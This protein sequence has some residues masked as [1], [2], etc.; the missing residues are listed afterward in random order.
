[1][2]STRRTMD[3]IGGLDATPGSKSG[4]VIAIL[5]NSAFWANLKDFTP[6]VHLLNLVNTHLEG[7]SVPLSLVPLAF[8]F[9][10]QSVEYL[11]HPSYMMY[12]QQLS[13]QL[14]KR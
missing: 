9:V 11:D 12:L 14:D 8:L 5:F 2:T 7:D 3:D 1:M 10:I 6:V 4:D 13:V